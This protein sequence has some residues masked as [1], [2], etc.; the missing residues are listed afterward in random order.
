[1]ITLD[2]KGAGSRGVS[3]FRQSSIGVAAL[4]SCLVFL[5]L[6]ILLIWRLNVNWDE[7]F[8]LSHVHD[9]ERGNLTLVLQA[10][11]THL[12]RW[13]INLG[14]DEMREIAAGRLVMTLLLGVTILLI[15]KLASQWASP[16]AAALAALTFT[17]MVS[18]LKHGGSFRADSLLT[19]LLL[20]SVLLFSRKQAGIRGDIAAGALV[21]LAM[22]VTIKA[23]LAT[24]VFL[25]LALLDERHRECS[26]APQPRAAIVRIL[27]LGLIAGSVTA[28]LTGAHW[29]ALTSPPEETAG[30]FAL[31]SA[32]STLLDVGFVPQAGY[33]K[34]SLAADALAWS[35][36]V[37]GAALAVMQRRVTPLALGLALVPILIYRNTF[38]Y[39]YPVMMAPASV[40]TAI[41][42]D[43]LGNWVHHRLGAAANS[44]ILG[45]VL[46][47]LVAVGL[48]H[49]AQLWRNEQQAQR[50]VVAAVHQIFPDPF[51]YIDHSGMIASFPKANFFMSGWGLQRYRQAG[52]AFMP[53]ALDERHPAFVLSNRPVLE[54]GHPAFNL[55]LPEDREL[56]EQTYIPYWGPIRVAGAQ[57]VIPDG[58]DV[59]LR[60]PF[61]GKYRLEST[62]PVLIE[63]KAR[64]GAD[65]FDLDGT[66]V[67]I[68]RSTGM[69]GTGPLKVRLILAGARPPPDA[70]PP[71]AVLY[72][73]L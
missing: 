6:K 66:K 49:V 69:A 56:I 9:L 59:E 27:L 50:E 48:I 57:A 10:V 72:T 73:G 12:F 18:T 34:E 22:S 47:V 35:L 14:G 40:L 5:L 67:R 19:P 26:K 54:P 62:E 4:A 52:I 2:N 38:P 60:V 7:F 8:Y 45:V 20:G 29:L 43:S 11:H 55:L 24:P 1:M 13:L 44:R 15:W 41:T 21:G 33:F 53:R 17:I 36:I 64:S 58:G 25:A 3:W 61:P 16:H 46:A 51:A 23:A 71:T 32:Q 65:V 30:G 63:G 28:L 37:A 68:S 70:L 42:F 31:R 39:Y